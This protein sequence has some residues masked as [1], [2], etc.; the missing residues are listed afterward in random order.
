MVILGSGRLF[1]PNPREAMV[2]GA[3][4]GLSW[5]SLGLWAGWLAGLGSGLSGLG[6]WAGL[7]TMRLLK[8]TPEEK[9]RP[10]RLRRSLLF[11]FRA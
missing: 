9:A 5:G 3:L 10:R 11:S 6:L 1:S 7:A 4:L 2:L 8:R